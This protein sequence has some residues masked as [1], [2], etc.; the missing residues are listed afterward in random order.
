M[1]PWAQ[2]VGLLK[3]SPQYHPAPQHLAHAPCARQALPQPSALGRMGPAAG[4]G[5]GPVRAFRPPLPPPEPRQIISSAVIR[6]V[7]G[8]LPTG[9]PAQAASCGPPPPGSRLLVRMRRLDFLDTALI[10]QIAIQLPSTLA[11]GPGSTRTW[12]DP[13]ELLA[14]T[15]AGAPIN[16]RPPRL[17]GHPRQPS[18]RARPA[19]GSCEA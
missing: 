18:D 3:T 14:V 4:E 16:P 10:F 17:P 6:S 7:P 1:F 8:H 15:D 12:Q 2:A 19:P 9:H 5:S 11:P 13:Q